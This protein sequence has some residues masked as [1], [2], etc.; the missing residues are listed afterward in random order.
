MSRPLIG[1]GSSPLVC[2]ALV[3]EDEDSLLRELEMAREGG[4]AA[5]EWRAD[6]FS[7]IA[8]P[9]QVLALARRMRDA[10][11]ELALIFTV[12]SERE[13][14]RAVPLA[15]RELSDLETALCRE[16]DFDYLDCELGRG[17]SDIAR[18]RAAAHESGTR[19]IASHH[20]FAG[21]PSKEFIL[22]KFAE[23]ERL[24]LDVAK[25]SVMPRREEDV[26][27]LLEA[28]LEGKRRASLPLITMSMGE[29][30]AVSRIVGGLFGSSLTFASGPRASA[31]GQIPLEEL[32][33]ALAVV[34]KS[35]GARSPSNPR[36]SP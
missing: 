32:L 30:G 15:D 10:A 21:T 12:R 36:L 33:A 24:G 5:L 28:T 34:E 16:C 2:V 19:I 4:A 14:G 31:P 22:G 6:F 9:R 23:A 3:G 7:G 35:R 8:V 27:L 1:E 13:G 26:L 17:E 25:V 20:D 29:L 11:P 18:L